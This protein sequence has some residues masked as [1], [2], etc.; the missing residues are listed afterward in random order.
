MTVSVRYIV[1][2]V[3][4]A[5]EFYTSSLRFELE[6]HPGPGFAALTRD[7]LRLLINAPGAGGAG[8]AGGEPEPGGWN[9]FQL[10]VEDLDVWI[11]EL[12]ERGVRFRGD[13]VEGRGGRQ[14]LVEDP[15]G[16]L[17]ELFA[18]I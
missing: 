15:S 2:D 18:S 16:N 11:A 12:S 1:D 4:A 17:I 10:E 6:M 5:I 13:P 9:R 7:D 3:D 14:V 8:T